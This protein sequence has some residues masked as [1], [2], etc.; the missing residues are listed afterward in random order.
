MVFVV[1]LA[2]ADLDW[3][4]PESGVDFFSS[5]KGVVLQLLACCHPV[6][7]FVGKFVV[8]DDQIERAMGVALL[9][10]EA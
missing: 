7:S 2:M 6:A 10:A 3:I 5:A 1:W 9:L 8:F 4:W